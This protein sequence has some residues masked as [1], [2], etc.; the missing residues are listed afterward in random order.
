MGPGILS[1]VIAKDLGYSVLNESLKRANFLAQRDLIRNLGPP[2]REHVLPTQGP[3][4]SLGLGLG[5]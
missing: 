3:G 1:I 5:V 4:Y 2:K